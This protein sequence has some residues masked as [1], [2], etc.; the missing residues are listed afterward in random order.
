M[1]VGVGNALTMGITTGAGI[2]VM[3]ALVNITT[4]VLFKTG[5]IDY[6]AQEGMAFS[7]GRTK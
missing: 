3:L 5:W 4:R 1:A 6:A 2:G 7:N